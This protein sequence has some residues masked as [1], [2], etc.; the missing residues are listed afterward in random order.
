MENKYK[1]ES[2][3]DVAYDILKNGPDKRLKFSDLFKE[4]IKLKN[5]SE[6]DSTKIISLFYTNLTLDGRFIDLK[7]GEWG[8]R[9]REKFVSN[10]D[11]ESH[12][13]AM[14]EDDNANEETDDEDEKS[15]DFDGEE[16]DEDSP[17]SDE[18]SSSDY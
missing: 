13:A 4:V 17:Y 10:E 16:K 3:A 1:N 6:E 14:E 9:E 11:V 7:D 5:K 18:E 12:Y 8:L 2:M 15:E